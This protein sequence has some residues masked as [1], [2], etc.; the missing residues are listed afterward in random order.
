MLGQIV[1]GM[2]YIFENILS[3]LFSYSFCIFIL[4]GF[5]LKL[6]DVKEFEKII[7]INI[8]YYILIYAFSFIILL[9][10]YMKRI[11][12]FEKIKD[13]FEKENY[14]FFI[15]SKLYC[16]YIFLWKFFFL[17]LELNLKFILFLKENLIFG[18]NVISLF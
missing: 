14:I 16:F 15:E 8:I 5:N 1:S 7:N 18:N 10:S 6:D 11:S 13:I 17:F 4:I 3:F 12:Q 2:Y 9:F